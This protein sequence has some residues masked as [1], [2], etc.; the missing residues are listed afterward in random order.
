MI[1]DTITDAIGRKRPEIYSKTQ[2]MT[3]LVLEHGIDEKTAYTL[4]KGHPPTDSSL[5]RFKDK[6]QKFSVTAPPMVKDARNVLRNA[7]R[8]KAVE[9]E[10]EAVNRKGEVVQYTERIIPS[11]TNALAAASMVLDR[12]Q[13]VVHK[14]VS[15]TGNVSISPVDFLDYMA[16]DD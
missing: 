11:Y 15:M 5:S 9:I 14:S 4:V 7:M 6:V 8:F 2:E 12:D 3:K 1:T 16:K 13:P 10:Q